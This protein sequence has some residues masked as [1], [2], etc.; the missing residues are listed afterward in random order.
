MR[1]EQFEV[2]GLAIKKNNGSTVW[3]DSPGQIKRLLSHID[4]S[5]CGILC[6]NDV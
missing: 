1:D 3:L 6:H 2:I 4:F 5:A